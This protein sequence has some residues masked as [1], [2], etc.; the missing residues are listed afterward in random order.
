MT[1]LQMI[2]T[3]FSFIMMIV[4]IYF[5]INPQKVLKAKPHLS[6]LKIRIILGLAICLM[7][8]SQIIKY[9]VRQKES[10]SGLTTE[11]SKN[12]SDHDKN[13]NARLEKYSLETRNLNWTKTCQKLNAEKI[14]E[15]TPKMP[16]ESA[17]LTALA[18]CSCMAHNLAQVPEF[19]KAQELLDEGKNFV[20]ALDAAFANNSAVMLEKI[21][22]CM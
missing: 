10:P 22:P 19:K 7:I 6:I 8:G 15:T 4:A 16:K 5:F 12:V 3:A 14:I 11:Q 20:E 13:M 1:S 18:V 9:Q 2:T 17:D 21:K